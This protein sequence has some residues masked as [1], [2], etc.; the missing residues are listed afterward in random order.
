[1]CKFYFKQIYLAIQFML[2]KNIVHRDIKLNNI[3]FLDEYKKT[4]VL[5]DF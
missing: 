4:L 2:S 5:I 3:L 1:M